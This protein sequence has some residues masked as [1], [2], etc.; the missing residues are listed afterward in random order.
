MRFIALFTIAFILIVAI[1]TTRASENKLVNFVASY[2]G[3]RDTAYRD[4]TG[5]WTIG[6]GQTRD[7]AEGDTI[8]ESDAWD[9][10]KLELFVIDRIIRVD[11]SGRF[12]ACERHALTSFAYNTG[13][14]NL[15]R[16][17]RGRS[18][19]EIAEAMLLYIYSKGRVLQGLVNRRADEVEMFLNCD[20]QRG[21]K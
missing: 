14:G 15:T 6:Y 7:V 5:T 11:H 3:F 4:P 16:L 19:D 10:L 21:V 18:N 8:T 9:D 1:P 2:E 17:L 12:S 13:M 20:Y